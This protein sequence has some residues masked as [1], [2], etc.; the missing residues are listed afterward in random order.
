MDWPAYQRLC[1]SPRYW[2][3]WMLDTCAGLL[4]G[5]GQPELADLLRVALAGTALE[6]PAGHRGPPA[7]DMFMLALGGDDARRVRDAVRRAAA[8]DVRTAQGRGLGGFVAA[9]DEYLRLL[10]PG[11]VGAVP[12]DPR[13]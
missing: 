8:A 5:Q 7:T 10:A 4:D 1:D 2:S 12:S 11:V 9:W 13:S 6:K 3:R